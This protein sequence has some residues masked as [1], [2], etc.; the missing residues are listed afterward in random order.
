MINYVRYVVGP[1]HKPGLVLS[2]QP[3]YVLAMPTEPDPKLLQ[4]LFDIL[5]GPSKKPKWTPVKPKRDQKS[6][7]T[8]DRPSTRPPTQAEFDEMLKTDEMLAAVERPYKPKST[9]GNE[10][11]WGVKFYVEFAIW[12][13]V[14]WQ[15]GRELVRWLLG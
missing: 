8:D 10:W 5:G 13:L 2:R 4:E 14:L 1:G 12:S 11:W 9:W 6:D 15:A 3:I 7:P